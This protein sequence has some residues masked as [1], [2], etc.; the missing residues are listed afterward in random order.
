MKY[1]QPLRLW[2][3]GR[4][5]KEQLSQG[6]FILFYC[7]SRYCRNSCVECLFPSMSPLQPDEITLGGLR[8]RNDWNCCVDL[9]HRLRRGMKDYAFFFK[10]KYALNAMSVTSAILF[11]PFHLAVSSFSH[12]EKLQFFSRSILTWPSLGNC[13]CRELLPVVCCL[14]FEVFLIT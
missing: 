12:C 8:L 14:L 13:I 7:C 9:V 10:F 2:I 5:N 1:P 11:D 3:R 4:Q 6:A